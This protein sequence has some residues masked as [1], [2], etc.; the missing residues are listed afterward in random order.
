MIYEHI[1]LTVDELGKSIYFDTT[2]LGFDVLKKTSFHVYLY[3]G[4]DMIELMQ[5][6]NLVPVEKQ[7]PKDDLVGCMTEVTGGTVHIG[8]RVKNREKA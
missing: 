4:T 6:K 8:I 2:A 5:S 7:E 1:G 3:K